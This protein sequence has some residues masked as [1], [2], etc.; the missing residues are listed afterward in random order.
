MLQIA[1]KYKLD[2]Y[3]KQR[4]L[5]N[6]YIRE[7]HLPEYY[8]IDES[9]VVTCFCYGVDSMEFVKSVGAQQVTCTN[10]D[11]RGIAHFATTAEWLQFQ[12]VCSKFPTFASGTNIYLL[13][14][15]K[16]PQ[17]ANDIIP[18]HSQI[19]IGLV[20]DGDDVAKELNNDDANSQNNLFECHANH[21]LIWTDY[22]VIS[23]KTE[24]DGVSDEQYIDLMAPVTFNQDDYVRIE[25]DY[26]LKMITL[27]VNTLT[28]VVLGSKDI[29]WDWSAQYRFVVTSTARDA[30]VEF[31]KYKY[32]HNKYK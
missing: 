20:S 18:P 6:G 25:M 8:K 30:R 15:V 21:S 29:N 24:V 26:R 2:T 13:K 17:P 10:N 32:M 4:L 19:L 9:V 31:V 28:K 3:G 22:G 16:H 27:H 11:D 7:M 5:V 1:R 12:S 14:I 23:I